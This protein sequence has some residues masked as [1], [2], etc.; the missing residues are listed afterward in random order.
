MNDYTRAVMYA[1]APEPYQRAPLT[2]TTLH[3]LR[4]FE[5]AF[6]LI[7][8]DEVDAFP[9][10][11]NQA[12][13]IVMNRALK[14]HAP[15]VFVTATPT[16]KVKQQY[17]SGRLSGIHIPIRFH[18]GALPVPS[19]Q[20]ATNWRRGLQNKR[21]PTSLL[22]W[23]RKSLDN[24]RSVFL[25]VPEIRQVDPLVQLLTEAGLSAEGSHSKDPRRREKVLA[26][27]EG[28][29]DIMVC[30]TILERGVTIPSADV[31]VLGSDTK[32]FDER[33]LVQM[34]G[35]AGRSKED[36][37][38]EVVFFHN[39]KTEEMRRAKKHIQFM[40]REAEPIRLD[41]QETLNG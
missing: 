23:T 26:F 2:L 22:K 40:N 6:D 5:Q 16:R 21:L 17:L 38:G 29:F 27:R 12:L 39:G 31:A 4:R 35:R 25:F 9:F 18:R 11:G 10:Q 8:I 15:K 19:F 34:A 20:W 41:A 36:P 1:D 37:H 14:R 32:L 13:E 3:Q 30:T 7:I 33:A 24:H 28:Q